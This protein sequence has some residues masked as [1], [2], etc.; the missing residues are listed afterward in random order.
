[1]KHK[2][3]A[4]ILLSL[5]IAVSA[6]IFIL[7]A[8]TGD[9]SGD[10]SHEV[11]EDIFFFVDSDDQTEQSL[12]K[13]VRKGAHMA[14]YAALAFLLCAYIAYVWKDVPFYRAALLAWFFS[15]LYG[16]TD[17][18]HQIFVPGRGPSSRDVLI[19]A[20]GAA[21]GVL[22]LAVLSRIIRKMKEKYL[23]SKEGTI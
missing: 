18:I 13:L 23:D 19:D 21:L 11:A 16:V 2:F 20:I 12:P 14:E 9:V 3:I 15:T 1:M 4:A 22:A 6:V 7:S 17:E 10:M 8:Q 5:V